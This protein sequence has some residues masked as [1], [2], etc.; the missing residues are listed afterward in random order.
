MDLNKVNL[1]GPSNIVL[2]PFTCSECG[3][4][5][6]QGNK[7]NQHLR[8]SKIKQQRFAALRKTINENND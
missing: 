2:E 5:R 8:C 1:R 6:S 3:K 7:R 4:P